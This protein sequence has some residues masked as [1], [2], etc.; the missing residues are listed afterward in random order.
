MKAFL[1]IALMG[2]PASAEERLILFRDADEPWSETRDA[3]ARHGGRVIHGFPGGGAIVDAAPSDWPALIRNAGGEKYVHAGAVRSVDPPPATRAGRFALAAWNR[4]FEKSRAKRVAP[5]PDTTPQDGDGEG[6]ADAPRKTAGAMKAPTGGDFY[7]TSEFM[8]GEVAVAILLPE[9]NGAIDPSTE[10]WTTG[11]I[12]TV[13]AEIQ[14]GLDFWARNAPGGALSFVYEIPSPVPTPYE[15]IA[16]P[17]FTLALYETLWT[18]GLFDTLGFHTGDTYYKGRSYLN[19]VRDTLGSDWA[20]AAIVAN[21]K[22]DPDG[23]FAVPAAKY[24]FSYFG[25]PYLVVTSDAGSDGIDNLD[26]LAAHEMGHSFYALDE[27]TGA[28]AGCTTTAGYEQMET[29][30]KEGDGCATDVGCIMK[31]WVNALSADSLCPWTTGQVGDGDDD[32]DNIANILDTYPTALLDPI[33]DSLGVYTPAITGSAYVNPLVNLNWRG[34]GNNITLNT[35]ASVEVRIDGGAWA[36]ASA[37]DGLF[38]SAGE[39]YTFIPPAL[40]ETLHVIECRAINSVANAGTTFAADTVLIY[41][42]VPPAPVTSLAVESFDSSA[43]L[44]WLNPPNADLAAVMI[45]VSTSAYPADTLQGVLVERRPALPLAADTLAVT[46]LLPDVVYYY[47]LFSLDEVPNPSP[48]AQVAATPLYPPPPAAL[49]TPGAGSLYVTLTPTFRWQPIV[50]SDPLDT[51]KAYT[52]QIASDSLFTSLLVN[53]D[54]ATGSP[55]DT[56]WM[57]DSLPPGTPLWW[58]IRGKDLLSGT[59]GY[60]GSGSKFTTELPLLTVEYVDSTA[61]A[62]SNFMSG[63]TLDPLLDALVEVRFTPADSLGVGGH[64]GWLH[65]N[66]TAWDSTALVFDRNE[67]GYSWWRAAV[68][69]GTGF[70]RGANVQFYISGNDPNG[71]AIVAD[72]G[73]LYYDFS[74]AWNPLASYHVPLTVEPAAT[75]RDPLHVLDTQPSVTM[76]IGTSP[77]GSITGGEVV[78]HVAGDPVYASVPLL[79]DTLT[80][81]ID[82]Y[83]ALIGSTFLFG[84]TVEYYG[85]VWGGADFDTTFLFGTDSTSNTSLVAADAIAAPYTFL[86]ES[87]TGVEGGGKALPIVDR[88]AGNTPNPFNPVTVISYGLASNT[89][90]R[91]DIFDITGRRVATLVDADRAAGWH[92]AVWNGQSDTGGAAG[93]GVYFY[94]IDTPRWSDTARMI[95][96]R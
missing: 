3:I 4:T 63:D 88:L 51:L 28:G 52:I 47:S 26:A 20:V 55:A 9:S 80:A 27:Y 81:G 5:R 72:K 37:A 57:S 14:A 64:S 82:Y 49:Y 33:A 15:P 45:R 53:I 90:V 6:A 71:M 84:S 70:G 29:Q 42:G 32:A 77:A 65:W 60:W 85:R 38:D 68:P 62:Y 30:N 16:H 66:S 39:A 94:R 96:I 13:V 19:A 1:L 56:F 21:S 83:S 91:L 23:R 54:G 40:S 79:F 89:H 86:V 18:R 58:R 61:S 76:R 12:D 59:Y 7:D 44:H 75:M 24:G 92:E 17:A 11:E 69:Y 95:L 41:D 35:I 73:G 36:A 25:G 74:S 93:S 87:A 43:V 31:R 2:G 48:A 67:G 78:Y 22:N 10:N 8:L 46:G 50:L 34:T